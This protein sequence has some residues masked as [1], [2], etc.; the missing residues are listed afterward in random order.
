[1]YSERNKNT[2]NTN[3]NTFKTTEMLYFEV[4]TASPERINRKT[5]KSETKV[6]ELMH[7]E[8]WIIWPDIRLWIWLWLSSTSIF[9]YSTGNKMHQG[10]KRSLLW[11]VMVAVA[12]V[13]AA[14]VVMVMVVFVCLHQHRC[15][16][17]IIFKPFKTFQTNPIHSI[18][19]RVW[20]KSDVMT[21]CIGARIARCKIQNTEK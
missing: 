16:I 15:C 17:S 2:Y 12:A 14:V 19:R 10:N 3:T 20:E 5:S 9:Q 11:L 21:L 7:I 8:H 13:A 4:K 6:V 18:G 1:M